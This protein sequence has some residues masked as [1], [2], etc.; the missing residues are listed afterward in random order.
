MVF[1]STF[2]VAISFF[3]FFG[4]LFYF[5]VPVKINEILNKLIS[6]IKTELDE[7]EEL[8]RETKKLLDKS[9][10]KLDAASKDTKEILDQAK[11][12]ADLMVKQMTEK[13]DKSVMIK[14]N[15]AEEKMKQMKEQV[16]KDIKSSAINISISS[17]EEII[18]NTL[19]ESKLDNIFQKK[20][21]ESKEAL[22]KIK[23]N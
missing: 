14:K 8:R 22:K 7:S 5:K 21:E 12:D 17:V 6:E 18:K 3:I 10:T 2:W 16:I 20:L 13:F 4:L 19:D 9:Q 15:S 11:K 23:S 1:D